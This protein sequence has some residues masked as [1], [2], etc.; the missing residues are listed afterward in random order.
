MTAAGSEKYRLEEMQR[1]ER[2]ER[3]K[4]TGSWTPRWF[5]QIEAPQLFQGAF[6]GLAVDALNSASTSA[7]VSATTQP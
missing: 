6:W 3:E 1:A 2:R 4:R 5:K 7:L